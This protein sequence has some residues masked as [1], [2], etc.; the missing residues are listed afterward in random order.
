MI[1]PGVFADPQMNI[2]TDFYWVTGLDAPS[3][4]QSIQQRGPRGVDGKPYHAST[5]WEIDW[6]YRWIESR[7]WCRITDVNVSI[8]IHYSLPKH[9][10]LDKL[11]TPLKEKWAAYRD[12]LFRHEQQ[13]KDHG[14]AAAVELENKLL[15]LDQQYRCSELE[16]KASAVAQAVLDKYDRLEKEFDR[17]TNHGI[18][19]G[20]VLP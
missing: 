10:D 8:D 4:R 5:Q 2:H 18:N 6:A 20:I 17:K 7:P 11:S 16:L 13:H 9:R 19:Q 3:I 14:I 12:A 1:T 15:M